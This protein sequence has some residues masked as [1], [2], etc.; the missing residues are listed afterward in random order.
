MK[1][2]LILFSA[3]A[4][5]HAAESPIRIDLG[6]GVTLDLVEVAA[7][8]FEQGSPPSEAGRGVDE[9]QRR[10]T[11]SKNYYISRT[12]VTKS[13]WE[14]F[15]AETGYRTEA[16][17][18]TSGGFGWDGN[19]LVQK[20]FFT[21]S[22]PGFQ[23]TADHPVCLVTFPDAQAFCVWLERKSKRRT[24]LPT[25]AQW[26][27]ACRA[28]TSS[29]WHTGED[30]DA[31]AWHKSNAGN[32]TR[33][34]NSRPANAWGL[35]IGG[36]VSEWCLDW[37][38]PYPGGPAT[39]PLQNQP[40]PGDKARRV[41]RGGS[42]LRDAKNTRSAA[43]YRADP[44]SRNA[45]IGFRVVC[46]EVAA[47]APSRP[48]VV[49]SLPKVE[50]EP[51]DAPVPS[52]PVLVPPQLPA[53]MPHSAPPMVE[54]IFNGLGGLLCLLIPIG[55][56]IAFIKLLAGHGKREVQPTLTL[57]KAS[58]PR[59]PVRKTD[60]GF[61][62]HGDWP[63]GALLRLRYVVGGAE[64]IADLAYRPGAEGQFVYTGARPDSV[65]V[66][67]DGGDPPPLPT[68]FDA[69][70]SSELNRPTVRESRDP[71]PPVFPSAY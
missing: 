6:A 47:A 38:A 37:Y 35:H 33:P 68:L 48:P 10:V 15:V 62:I 65:S 49:P 20:K 25:E 24:S 9:I 5:V 8:T 7:G 43:R 29:A 18:G 53:E 12:S 2:L 57:P 61:W 54:R 45:D 34:V 13:Q 50:A 1:A 56:I 26:E 28:G 22:N 67:P 41:L 27:Y 51:G 16:E 59:P 4:A 30:A 11:I 23:Q 19:A 63:E 70:T 40:A 71:R 46:A 52:A 36:N 66:V 21:W 14:R 60:D 42:W 44:R 39:D 32:G 31:V 17:T 3:A 55:V 64:T 69:P 58:L